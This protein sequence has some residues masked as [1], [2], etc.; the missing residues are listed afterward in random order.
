MNARRRRQLL[1]A[2]IAL[3][4]LVLVAMPL[5]HGATIAA[6]TEVRLRVEPVDPTD[7]ARGSYVALRYE[8]FDEL[9]VPSGASS[10][11]SVYVELRNAGERGISEPSGT[12]VLDRDELDVGDRWIRLYVGGVEGDELTLDEISTW[13]ASADQAQAAERDLADGHAL[14]VVSLDDDGSPSLVEGVEG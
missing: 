8:G 11:D 3:Q 10:G 7:L 4:A 2:L 12:V 5:R 13:Y 14:A 9:E 6:G 1:L